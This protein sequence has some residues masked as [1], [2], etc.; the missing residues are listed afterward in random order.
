[1]LP[2]TSNRQFGTELWDITETEDSEQKQGRQLA[3]V[4]LK[5]EGPLIFFFWQMPRAMHR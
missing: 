1:V 4:A 2:Q 5:H 3:E